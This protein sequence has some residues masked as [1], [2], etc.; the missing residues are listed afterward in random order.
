MSKSNETKRAITYSLLAHINNSKTLTNGQLDIFVPIVKKALATMSKDGDIRGK[1]ITEICNVVNSISGIEIPIPVLRNILKIIKNT[2]A[3][4]EEKYFDLYNDD[5]FWIKRFLFSDFDEFVEKSECSIE[6]IQKLFAKFCKL[7]KVS[8]AESDI[9]KFIENNVVSL[10]AYISNNGMSDSQ[11]FSIEAKFVSYFKETDVYDEIRDLFIGAILSSY[12]YYVPSNLDT[13]T[14]LLLDTNFIV[15]LLDLNTPESTQTCRQLLEIGAN[16]GFSFH[17]LQDTLDET[18]NLLNYKA[19]NIDNSVVLAYVNKEDI[20]NACKR[21]KLSKTDLQR[22]SDNLESEIKKVCNITIIPYTE[23]IKN[24]AKVSKEFNILKQYR[25]TEKSAL[26]DAMCIQY[27]KEKRSNKPIFEFTKAKCWW[28]NNAVSHDYE[29]DNISSVIANKQGAL[30]EMIKVDDLLC[31]LWLSAPSI[32]AN[33]MAEI[34][35]TSL[36]ASTLN[37][38][39]PKARII[40]ELD[41][42]IQ[43]YKSKDISEKDVYLLSVRIANGQIKDIEQINTLAT[44]NRTEFNKRV[45]EE[46]ERQRIEE[47]KKARELNNLVNSLLNEIQTIKEHQ[48][49]LRLSYEGRQQELNAEQTQA[50]QW[51]KEALE[52]RKK[53]RE[54]YIQNEIRR[55]QWKTWRWIIVVSILLVIVIIFNI[56][57]PNLLSFVSN[58]SVIK[59]V[60]SLLIPGLINGVLIKQI[61]DKYD[62]SKINEFKRSIDIPKDLQDE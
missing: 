52:R 7:S 49:N 26:H 38:D 29:E 62:I 43:K 23:P 39:L 46:A 31:L 30:P 56:L 37:K 13:G 40:K 22:I 16:M 44:T 8:V 25:S 2:I 5:G 1:N 36:I 19:E 34:G 14:I 41:E 32:D 42:N 6:K 35:L 47:D 54:N 28:V 21:R 60:L 11:D 3:T 45:K 55:W 15:S 27:V 18:K 61:Y 10:S 50:E 58:N 51:K 33:L 9:I 59:W 17:V 4:E 12:L 57:C 24:K 48:Q 20:C 53:D